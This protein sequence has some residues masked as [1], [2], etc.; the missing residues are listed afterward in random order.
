MDYHKVTKERVLFI[1]ELC[2][3]PVI[4]KIK[5]CFW[6]LLMTLI[7]PK[8]NL[9]IRLKPGFAALRFGDNDAWVHP[10]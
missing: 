2:I 9:K 4:S 8:I 5:A 7:H 6:L 1:H 3:N 10:S